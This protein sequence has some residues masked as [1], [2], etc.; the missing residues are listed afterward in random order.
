[1]KNVEFVYSQT[2]KSPCFIDTVSLSSFISILLIFIVFLVGHISSA[3]RLPPLL[4]VTDNFFSVNHSLFSSTIEVPVTINSL[5]PEHQT[6]EVNCILLRSANFSAITEIP[7]TFSVSVRFESLASEVTRE[8][9]KVSVSLPFQKD[10]LQ[11][12]PFPI[13]NEVISNF[14]SVVLKITIETDLQTLD[15]FAFR[16]AF[17][18][19]SGF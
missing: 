19:P 2:S 7:V 15:G 3:I 5:T 8:P 4:H 14:T 12:A 6:I 13:L 11:S 9:P 10:S 18:D 16:W 17:A 1:M